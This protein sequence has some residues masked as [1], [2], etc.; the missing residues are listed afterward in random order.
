[1]T[2]PATNAPSPVDAVIF[3]LDGTLFDTVDD[4]ADALAFALDAEGL[5]VRTRDEVAAFMGNGVRNLTERCVPEDT[6]TEKVDAVFSAFLA[7]YAGHCCDRTKPYPGIPELLGELRAAGMACACVSNK[8]DPMVQEICRRGLPGML[9]AVTG[10]RHGVPRKPA[11]D[12]VNAI[13]GELGFAREQV[14]YVGDSE[15]DVATARNAGTRCIAC[16]WGFRTHDWLVDH[17]A[18]TIVSSPAELGRM[19]LAARPAPLA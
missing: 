3:D 8:A 7:R 13:L 15:V 11:P 5:P 4:L 14:V 19:L 6:P 17:G 10:E 9:D 18:E 2:Q 16:D 1:M 12:A